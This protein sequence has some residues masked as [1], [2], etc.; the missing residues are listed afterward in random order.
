MFT[1]ILGLSSAFIFGSADFLG[2][3]AAKRISP[4]L[5]TAI[6]AIS[7]LVVLLIVFPFVA[8]VWSTE[9]V[10]LGLLSG[11]NGAIAIGL[12]YACLAIGPMSILSPLTAVVSA[13]VPVTV[14]LISGESLGFFGFVAISLALVAVVLVGFVPEKGAVRPSLRA[15]LMAIGAGAA[16]GLFLVILDATP[17]D[18]G[19]I[20]ILGNR[21][22]NGLVMS[23][24][25]I[26]LTLIAR[27]K[28]AGAPI[29]ARAAIWRRGIYFAMA[30]GALDVIANMGILVGVRIGDLSVIAV[31]TALYPAGTV[32]LA[33]IVLRERIAPVQYV[34]LVL[35]ILAGVLLVLS[36]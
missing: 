5:T 4:I 21:V 16:I 26:V 20:P 12:L 19:I 14:G 30:A 17:D 2:G 8:S 10:I 1:V 31:L 28:S 23:S 18:S 22:A 34:G 13:I 36:G 27:R 33:A 24:L 29:A 35:G 32:I 3:F 15:L 7:G 25:F 9:A 6:G 11:V